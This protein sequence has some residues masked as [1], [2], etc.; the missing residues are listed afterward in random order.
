MSAKNL[1]SYMRN[2][3]RGICDICESPK[4]HFGI[5]DKYFC[6]KCEGYEL[7]CYEETNILIQRRKRRLREEFKKI[8]VKSDILHCLKVFLS[9]GESTECSC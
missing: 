3:D 1:I 6:Y 9:I 2:I 8:A 4:G 7:T 5:D